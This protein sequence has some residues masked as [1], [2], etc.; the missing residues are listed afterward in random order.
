MFPASFIKI[1]KRNDP[2]LQQCVF[3]TVDEMRPYLEKG[4]P[5]FGLQ[6]IDPLFI[7]EIQVDN[8]GDGASINAK[9][10]LSDIQ[11]F[12]GLTFRPVKFD[13]D[14]DKGRMTFWLDFDYLNMKGQYTFNGK[15]SFL[16]ITSTGEFQT[17]YSKSIFVF[18]LLEQTL[19]WLFK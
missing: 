11:V 17:N 6:P 2:N 5:E 3:N 7:K 15:L 10:K 12:G 16:N 18:I 4:I 8:T 13:V 14:V 19:R 9:A 1:C